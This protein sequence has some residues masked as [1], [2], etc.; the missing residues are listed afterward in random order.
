[1]IMFDY[2]EDL[3]KNLIS[4]NELPEIKSEEVF[5]VFGETVT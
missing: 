2:P 5:T 4:I 1:M 3:E